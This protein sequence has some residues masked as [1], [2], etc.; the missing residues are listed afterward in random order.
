[1]VLSFTNEQ[2]RREKYL[3]YQFEEKFP[4]KGNGTWLAKYILRTASKM[5]PIRTKFPATLNGESSPNMAKMLATLA[6]T[7]CGN[8]TSKLLYTNLVYIIPILTLL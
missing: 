6:A 1:M 4:G 8:K 7:I 2:H 3:P 5:L